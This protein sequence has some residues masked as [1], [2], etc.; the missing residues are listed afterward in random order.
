MHRA[1]RMGSQAARAG[2]LGALAAALVVAP[3]ISGC[4]DDELTIDPCEAMA[5]TCFGRQMGCEVA[6]GE[7]ACVACGS[8][9][10]ATADGTCAEIGGTPM[11]HEFAEFTTESGQEIIGLCQSWTLNNAEEIWVNAVELTQDESSHHSNWLFVP[12]DKFDGPDGVWECKERGYSQL[13]AAVY[14]GVLYAQSTQT[15]HEVQRFP[16]GAAVRIPPYSRII[17]DVHIL[18]VTDEALTG[19]VSLSLYT[20]PADEVKVKLA[21]FHLTYDGLAIPPQSESR[22]TGRCNLDSKFKTAG[23][24]PFEMDIYYI[25]P[26]YHALG[27][28]FFLDVYGGDKDGER[29]FEVGAYDGESHGKY[30]DPPYSV[31][32]IGLGFGCEFHNPRPEGVGWGFGDQEMCEVLGFAATPV[33][34]ESRVGNAESDGT[35]GEIQLFTGDCDTLAFEWENDKPGGNGP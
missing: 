22:F 35:D 4:A 10:Y 19:N 29:I 7:A 32:A 21:P 5:S 11:S 15:V 1:W 6:D 34:F 20:L 14:G 3:W 25:L 31:S 33:A 26:H 24:V 23:S 18:N 8:G 13:Q 2:R 27:S 30:Y 17:G 16:N 28:K 9:T 12:D